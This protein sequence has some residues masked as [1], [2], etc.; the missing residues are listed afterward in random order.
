MDGVH[1]TSPP[2]AADAYLELA[3]RIGDSATLNALSP[4]FG[5]LAKSMTIWVHV[6]REREKGLLLATPSRTSSSQA[7]PSSSRQHRGGRS[8]MQ[9]VLDPH[10]LLQ[11]E[12][13]RAV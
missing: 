4:Y 3:R 11:V 9:D 6:W 5:R 2:N 13:Q 1:L 10:E 7:T 8:A 12:R